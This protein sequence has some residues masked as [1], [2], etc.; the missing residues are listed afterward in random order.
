M[1]LSRNEANYVLNLRLSLK[2]HLCSLITTNIS[3]L[4][5]FHLSAQ[6]Q[7]RKHQTFM[8]SLMNDQSVIRNFWSTHLFVTEFFAE[9]GH[10]VPKLG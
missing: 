7:N 6:H 10:E 1:W 3:Y 9:G 4:L 2:D 8:T 5:H